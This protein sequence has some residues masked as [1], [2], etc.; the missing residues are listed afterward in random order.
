[1]VVELGLLVMFIPE[2][3]GDPVEALPAVCD[4]FAALPIGF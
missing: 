2:A 3:I 4:E 1:V